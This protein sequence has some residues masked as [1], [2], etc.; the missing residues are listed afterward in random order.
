MW[1]R[2]VY[3]AKLK[4]ADYFYRAANIAVV[5]IMILSL[6]MA[7][8][9]PRFI[10]T[11]ASHSGTHMLI[12]WDGGAAPSGW[13]IVTTYDGKF[14]RGE[15]PANAL[16]TGGGGTH[17]PTTSSL[18][19]SSVTGTFASAF[20]GNSASPSGHVHGLSSSLTIGAASNSDEPPF[21][22]LKLLRY[23]AGLPT[24]IPA[25]GIVFFDNDPGI[26]DTGW[27]R[28][29]A[30]DA[31]FLKAN[32]SV[33]TGGTSTHTHSLAWP[34]LLAQAT[35]FAVLASGQTVAAFNHTHTAPSS[36]TAT[37]S[38]T[39]LPPYVEPL[40][41]KA[42]ST[43]LV[44]IGTL[45]MFDGDPGANWSVRSSSGGTFYQQFLRPAATF[46]GTSQ[47]SA[48]HTH[49]NEVG[50]SGSA[51]SFVDGNGT[52][53]SDV[54]GNHTHNVTAVFNSVEN[55]PEYFNV[56]IAQQTGASM[57]LFWDSG[58][59]PTG[60]SAVND[61]NGR[62]PRG[63]SAGNYGLTG[64]S[65]THTPTTSVTVGQGSL[66]NG[67]SGGQNSV[68]SYAHGHTATTTNGS[69]SNDRASRTLQL[70]RYDAGVPNIIPTGAIALFDNSPGIPASGW[71]RQSA[72]DSKF[73]KADST[74][75]TN[76][77]SDTH[78]HSITWSSLAASTGTVQRG[79]LILN[80]QTAQAA[81]THNAPSAGN[82]TT[83]GTTASDCETGTVD[84][85]CLPQHVQTL[86]AKSGSD[87]PTL[88]VGL[89]AMFDGDPGGGWVIRSNSGQ[90]FYQRFL[91]GGSTYT[92]SLGSATH[93]H[94]NAT[95]TSPVDNQASGGTAESLGAQ[96]SEDN[97][98]HGMT[99]VFNA[100][101][102]TPQ[103][104]NVVVAEK[105]SFVLEQYRWYVDS[106]A[107]DVTDP[108][109]S[110]DLAP[111]TAIPVLPP[112]YDQPEVGKELRLRIKILVFGNNLAANQIEFKLQYKEGT[113]ASCT[114][115]TWSDVGAG[116]GGS[117]WRY[118]TSG[119]GNGVTLST[120]RFSPVSSVLQRYIKSDA[121]GTNPNAVSLGQTMEYDFHIEQN[122]ATPGAQYSFRVLETT[123]TLLS[124]YDFC[125][126][127][128]T[129]STTDVQMR[130]GNFFSNELERGFSWAD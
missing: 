125:P 39:S 5:Q 99:A 61:F 23:D 19:P 117:I 109:S 88:S 127:L 91:R 118:A 24:D 87:T 124:Q 112:A 73:V 41:A 129:E 102:H 89:T 65:T 9:P 49:A 70:I 107:E 86:L 53:S 6:F 31:N 95:T 62:M 43:T 38:T 37:G 8:F 12:L 22:S 104:F 40:M 10:P 72:F 27:T 119:V 48:N 18:T 90:P 122:G 36:P 75:G 57:L 103:Y 78:N 2:K 120:S 13:S 47:G 130:H 108:W 33:A 50:V 114:T 121:S 105:V 81:H 111:S 100:A 26:P 55:L 79:P 84:N 98:T 93:T 69:A 29:S 35:P 63:E 3:T 7:V 76:A 34:S 116:G 82:T 96:T 28:Q 110:L 42:D 64:G 85:Q 123:G 51:S 17:A 14:P 11:Q 128:A 106:N 80:L 54:N 16:V 126:T 60:W 20:S 15:S 4:L 71:T 101:D 30:Q 68:A 44:P 115:E 66:D 59:P 32:S 58:A 56:V 97:H 52:A 83:N 77:G 25:G 21:R 1:W 92:E 94:L 46:N 74:A 113:D 45:A 67:S